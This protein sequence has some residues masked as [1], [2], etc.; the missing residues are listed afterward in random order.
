[1]ELYHLTIYELRSL[2][3][4]G[5]VTAE[6]VTTSI[7]A[8]I[9]NLEPRV[10]AYVS[11]LEEAAQEQARICDQQGYKESPAVLAGVP[12]A[13]KDVIC[14]K[15]IRT[16]CGSKIL[17]NFVPPFDATV[18][19]RI[20]NA[21]GIVLGKTNMDEFAM[22]SSTENSAFGPSRNPWNLDYTPGGDDRRRAGPP[23]R[24]HRFGYGGL[25]STACFTLRC[26]W[27]KAYIWKGIALRSGGLCLF[28]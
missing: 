25:N 13:V 8:R 24:G 20:K 21:G 14:S 23:V 6:E 16:T 27:A 3:Q 18:A 4:R 19:E 12:L 10:S 7:F 17:A 11:L 5:D 26:G 15:G 2:L 22:G 1:M 9:R 28:L